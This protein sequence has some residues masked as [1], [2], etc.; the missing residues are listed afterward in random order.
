MTEISRRSVLKMLGAG[1]VAS[2]APLS[3]SNA[4]AG[5]RDDKLNILCWEGYNSAEVLDPF[6]E[7]F[8][9]DVHAESATNDP[10]MVNKI[11]AGETNVWDLVNN[12]SFPDGNL[13]RT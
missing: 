6:R 7:K 8:K 9:A 2:A 12:S 4:V 3:I 13:T 5:E 10:T 1:A 11:R